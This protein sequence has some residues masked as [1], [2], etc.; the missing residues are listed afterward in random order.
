M[1]VSTFYR[2][3]STPGIS[4][5]KF[6]LSQ[7]RFSTLSNL[8]IVGDFNVNFSSSS[9]ISPFLYELKSLA[10][11]FFSRHI[12]DPTHYSHSGTLSII[13]LA[14]IP[15]TFLSNFIIL[16]PVY[17][18]DNNSILLS[19]SLPYHSLSSKVKSSR[20]LDVVSGYT[21]KLMFKR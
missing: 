1:H 8:I 4:D 9:S 18:S 13:D 7:L 2:P 10:N 11:L 3:P 5:Q 12:T 20:R 19:V 15:S 14:F 16:P 17:I 6:V 21:I